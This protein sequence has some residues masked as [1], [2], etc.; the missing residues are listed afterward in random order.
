MITNRRFKYFITSFLIPALISGIILQGVFPTF[1][2]AAF[3]T[4]ITSDGT[5]GSTVTQS[6]KVYNI[7]GGTIKGTN[8]FHSFGLFSVGTGDTASF[9]GPS[10]IANI[11]SRVTGG[12]QSMIDGILKST[13]S[14][15]QSLSAQSE[16]GSVW[17][18]C[19]AGCDRV[20]SCKHR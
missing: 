19:A 8:Q 1:S 16:W 3:T 4:T 12:Q 11:L 14:W 5:M 13:I 2:Y 17:T 15:R 10:G 7:D 20:I 6:G 9:N 18:Q